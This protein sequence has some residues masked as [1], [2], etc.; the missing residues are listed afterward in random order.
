MVQVNRSMD[1]GNSPKN[2][3]VEHIAIALDT[4]DTDFLSSILD[5][6]AVWSYVGG[7]ATTS[8]AILDQ[9][10]AVN[11]PTSLTVDHVMSHGKVG[12]VNGNVKRGKSEQRFCHVIEFTSVKCNR[13]CRIESYSG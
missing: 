8:E 3:M 2:K 11:K 5:S 7:T 6:E 9:V 1:C 4:Q 13:V 12:A 10:G